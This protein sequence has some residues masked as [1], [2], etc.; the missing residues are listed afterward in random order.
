MIATRFQ[1]ELERSPVY[2]RLNL[3]VREARRV[4]DFARWRWEKDG[5]H[6]CFKA[7]HDEV[8]VILREVGIEPSAR[9]LRTLAWLCDGEIESV[10]DVVE[11]IL[12]GRDVTS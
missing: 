12:A 9:Q 7:V 2:Q 5:P 10:V 4:A 1:H 11:L 3:V 8:V 6:P